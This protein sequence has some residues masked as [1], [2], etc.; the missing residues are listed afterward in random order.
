MGL[1]YMAAETGPQEARL[2]WMFSDQSSDPSY[3]LDMPRGYAT[4]ISQSSFV[5]RMPG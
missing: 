3:Q 1:P 5:G 2:S 4:T